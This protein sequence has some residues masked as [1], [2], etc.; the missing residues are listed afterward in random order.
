MRTMSSLTMP[1]YWNKEILEIISKQESKKG[2]FINEM[3]GAIPKSPLGHGRNPSVLKSIK[4]K[5]ICEFRSLLKKKKINFAYLLNSPL[6]DKQIKENFLKI[7]QHIKWILN[8]LNPESLIITSLEIMKIVREISDIPITI[9]TIARIQKVNDL[10]K[11]LDIKPSKVVVQHDTNRNFKN[12]INLV[13][14]AKKFQIKIEVMLTESCRRRCPI[15][16]KHY[17]AVGKGKSDISFHKSC[18][19]KK[20]NSPEEFLL[21]NF[22]R[23]EDLIFY[24]KLGINNFKITGRSKKPSWLPIVVSAYLNRKF[25]GNL[26]RLL[27]IDPLLSA[28]EWIYI[29]NSSLNG[30]LEKFPKTGKSN[31]EKKYCKK[32]IKKL[33]N[34]GN[35][36]VNG[37]EYKDTK[38]GLSCKSN[39][40]EIP[41]IKK[42]YFN[43]NEN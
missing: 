24:E 27:G 21:A 25:N 19:T 18:N 2:V 29:S 17:I 43:S 42:N 22:I 41:Q 35:F 6:T 13:K 32:W 15:M 28:E 5:E 3:Y 9:S 23:P 14:F 38:E 31:I 10:K 16:M 8:E 11:Y 34:E 33:Y 36:W 40:E 12:L 30:F 4:E 1:C 26:I 39:V 7:K 37:I 20:I